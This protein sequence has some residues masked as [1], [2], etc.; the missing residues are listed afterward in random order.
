MPEI[1]AEQSPS[2]QLI[3]Q[4]FTTATYDASMAMCRWTNGRISLTLDEVRE[5]PL[6]Q[7]CSEFNFGD[8]LLTM[9]VL[10]LDGEVGGDMV[11]TFDEKNGRQL[12]A[13][14]LKQPAQDSPTWSELEISALTETGNIL[15]CAYLNALTRVIGVELIPSPPYFIQD[16]GASVLQQ[17]LMNQA[18]HTDK[19]VIGRTTFLNDGTELNWNVFFIPTLGFREAVEKI[20]QHS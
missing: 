15:S 6:E 7:I 1:H 12:A 11:L 13:S 18:A 20:V 3:H 4:L 16:Y 9:V 19:I 14:L 5:L 17:T 2:L 8:E 10:T